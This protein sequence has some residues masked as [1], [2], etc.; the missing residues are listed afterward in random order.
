M[1]GDKISAELFL[2]ILLFIATRGFITIERPIPN[3]FCA[4]VGE[5]LTQ[6]ENPPDFPA[7][8]FCPTVN[9]AARAVQGTSGLEQVGW[10][11]IQWVRAG[12]MLSR[13]SQAVLA[14]IHCRTR[15]QS[16]G[17]FPTSSVG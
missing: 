17:G 3:L 6:V 5:F 12:W 9:R 4:Y 15:W 13:A 2:H 7:W 1:P 14:W 11:P 16:S 10:F 8:F